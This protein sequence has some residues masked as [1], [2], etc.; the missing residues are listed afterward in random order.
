[1]SV[2]RDRYQKV[3]SRLVYRGSCQVIDQEIKAKQ[4]VVISYIYAGGDK[5]LTKITLCANRQ[6]TSATGNEYS[7]T[8]K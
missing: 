1:M 4:P 8:N 5:A 6:G 7:L 2:T 3:V